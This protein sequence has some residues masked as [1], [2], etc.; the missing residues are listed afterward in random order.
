MNTMYL[1][2]ACLIYELEIKFLSAFIFL[3][4]DCKVKIDKSKDKNLR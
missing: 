2:E 3:N 4:P 1:W